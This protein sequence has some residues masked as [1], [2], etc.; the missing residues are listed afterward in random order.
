MKNVKIFLPIVAL[1][2]V[3]LFA[4][5]QE[6]EWDTLDSPELYQVEYLKFNS[7]MSDEAMKII[8]QYFSAANKLAGVPTPLMHFEVHSEDY[9]YIALWPIQEGKDNLIWQNSP[10]NVKWYKALVEVTGSEGKAKEI[11]EEFDACVS[12]S[13]IEM[14]KKN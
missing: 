8:D 14:A 1:I 10:N 2:F 4:Q 7:D 6:D 12:N 9:D 5:A 3:G 13:K 11:I